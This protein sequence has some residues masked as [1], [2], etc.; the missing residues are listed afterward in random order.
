MASSAARSGYSPPTR[1]VR[2]AAAA[3]TAMF[4]VAACAEG[5]PPLDRQIESVLEQ[6]RLGPVEVSVCIADCA[7]GEVLAGIDQK[8]ALIP[9]SNMKL[10]TS[11]T[12]LMVLGRDFDFKTE[13]MREGD[14]LVVLGAGDPGF[15]DPD[16]LKEMK[17]SPAAFIDR[18][19]EAVSKAGFK[20]I[21]EV[22]VDDRVFD[23]EFVH[24]SWPADQL[25]RW[26]C[27]EVSGLIFH[28]NVLQIFPVPGAHPGPAPMPAFEPSAPWIELINRLQTVANGGTKV[29]VYRDEDLRFIVSGSV[30]AALDEPVRVALHDAPS[31]FAHLL[32]DRL[33]ASGAGGKAPAWRLAEKEDRWKHDQV[34]A[35]VRTPLSTVLKRCNTES[36]N[37]YAEALMKRIGH[38]VT[39]QPGGW[40]SGATVLRMEVG[41]RVRIENGD[42]VI[43]DGS[44]M[45]RDNRVASQ[46]MAQWLAAIAR[47]SAGP[48]F[49]NSLAG[50]GEGTLKERFREKDKAKLR[51][52]VRG[53][54]GYLNGVQCLSGYVTS[55]SGDRRIA[56]SI[57][58]NNINAQA[59]SGSIKDFHEDI[60][61]AIDQWLGKQAPAP[62]AAAGDPQGG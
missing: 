7:T 25:N 38:D 48:V 15:G 37:L 28:A 26:Y 20:D 27:A 33:A 12:A 1:L 55:A 40:G 32:A 35:V 17:L 50:I 51:D 41:Q 13:L 49:I 6:A 4:S 18:L 8:K 43:A 29:V 58:V 53:K 59:R 62:T 11:G 3:V 52:R 16:L 45:S 10:L 19:A 57:L 2:M 31:L 36:H 21:R 42:L 60:V 9:A 56:F 22:V 34:L 24:A 54:S 44:G 5:A 46:T 14:R 61:G 30:M 47:S 39:G 23:R